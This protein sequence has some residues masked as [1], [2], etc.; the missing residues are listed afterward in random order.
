MLRPNAEASAILIAFSRP[1]C[2]LVRSGGWYC[3]AHIATAKIAENNSEGVMLG[4]RV[5]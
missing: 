3:P 4:G 1:F 2:R 5:S